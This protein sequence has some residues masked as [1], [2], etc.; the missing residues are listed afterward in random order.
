[1]LTLLVKVHVFPFSHAN[2]LCSLMN[3]TSTNFEII[4]CEQILKVL[5]ELGTE[6]APPAAPPAACFLPG[7][8]SAV[9]C[10]P[11]LSAQTVGMFLPAP[12]RRGLSTASAFSIELKHM[13]RR[14]T[15]RRC[16]N[17][18]NVPTLTASQ[19]L[20]GLKDVDSNFSKQTRWTC[21]CAF[22]FWEACRLSLTLVYLKAGRP[23][24]GLCLCACG[25]HLLN[26]HLGNGLSLTMTWTGTLS[27]CQTQSGFVS[28]FAL[29]RTLK[30]LRHRGRHSPRE[31]SQRRPGPRPGACFKVRSL[32]IQPIVMSQRMLCCGDLFCA[33]V[34]TEDGKINIL[35]KKKMTLDL[36]HRT[37]NK[38]VTVFKESFCII[39]LFVAV[40]WWI[41]RWHVVNGG[42]CRYY[43]YISLYC[44]ILTMGI[45]V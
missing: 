15:P 8:Q 21:T 30:A 19:Q 28:D 22:N 11:P 9:C 38:I 25:I 37:E 35:K 23:W 14:W 31:P 4:C 27:K 18:G 34:S 41:N 29:V 16:S 2:A 7:D 33:F 20:A 1:M 17:P 44:Y 43:I 13:S 24:E 45:T 42:R 40:T 3:S 39:F 10:V 36:K 5:H 6:A 26:S 32:G 12:E